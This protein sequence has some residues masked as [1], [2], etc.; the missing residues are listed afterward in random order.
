MRRFD[1]TLTFYSR[2]ISKSSS[3][4]FAD[5]QYFVKKTFLSEISVKC[6]RALKTCASVELAHGACQRAQEHLLTPSG[7][8]DR[9]FQSSGP[10]FFTKIS[11]IYE[12][13]SYQ[14]QWKHSLDFGYFWNWPCPQLKEALSRRSDGVRR[15]SWLVDMLRELAH[16]FRALWLFTEISDKKVFF[17]TKILGISEYTRR[18]FWY[19]SQVLCSYVKGAPTRKVKPRPDILR[20]V[21]FV[22][23]RRGCKP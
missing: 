14:I 1:F 7:L 9:A 3:R 18:T 5:S 16:V 2:G 19:S 4:I 13:Y 17:L 8:G 20:K 23:T 6:H 11:H 21:W 12:G 15:C 22:Q 10:A